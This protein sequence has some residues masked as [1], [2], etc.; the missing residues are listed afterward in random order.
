MRTQM[1]L[2]VLTVVLLMTFTMAGSWA[3]AAQGSSP[4]ADSSTNTK[5][6]PSAGREDQRDRTANGVESGPLTANE[7]LESKEAA[8]PGDDE[9]ERSANGD[10]P[11]LT[12]ITGVNKTIDDL[13][14]AFAQRD[15]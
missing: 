4:A 11:M 2:S 13:S 6:G 7:T 1:K 8:I 10:K 5:A 3:L 15:L 14:R 12:A 9:E